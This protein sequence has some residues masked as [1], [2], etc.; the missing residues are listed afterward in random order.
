VSDYK[1]NTHRGFHSP[2]ELLAG[3]VELASAT[4]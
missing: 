1:R 2:A 3:V 4:S